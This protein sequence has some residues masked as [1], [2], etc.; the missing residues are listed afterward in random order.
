MLSIAHYL[1]LSFALFIIGLVGVRIRRN[2]LIKLF[3]IE[4]I[5]NAAALNLAAFAR[6]FADASAQT[7][8]ALI[9]TIMMIEILIGLAIIAAIF[10]RWQNPCA[11][12]AEPETALTNHSI[13]SNA[14]SHAG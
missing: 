8:A 10:S 7:F 3:S 4:L 14:Q 12:P 1:L 9:F 11:V 13:T 5:F 6:L 2:L